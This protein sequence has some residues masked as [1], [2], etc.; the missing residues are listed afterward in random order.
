M[1][2]VGHVDVISRSRIAG[3]VVDL[4]VPDKSVSVSVHVNGRLRG[5]CWASLPRAGVMLPSGEAAPERCA[6]RLE[7]DPPL[8][9]FAEQRIEVMET[10]S[11]RAILNG[12]HILAPPKRHEFIDPLTPVLI[13][14]A[15]RS[16]TTWLMS[17]LACH[18]D[19]VLAD[20]YPY[21]I[22]Q[23]AYYVAAFRALVAS[24]DRERST[25]P[26][27]MFEA[28]KDRLIGANPYYEPD[29][30]LANPGTNLRDFY[31]RSI[32]EHYVMLFGTL[33]QKFYRILADSQQKRKARFFCEK[34]TLDETARQGARMFFNHVKE[35]VV[36]RDPGDLLCS[37]IAFWKHPPDRAM[38]LLRTAIHELHRIVREATSD[39]L[40]IRYEDLVRAPRRTSGV[41]SD[42]LGFD[43]LSPLA[44]RDDAIPASHR[45]SENPDA[46]IGRWRYDLTSDQRKVLAGEFAAFMYEFGYD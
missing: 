20:Q 13:T 10:R 27:T 44:D 28:G 45:T 1:S 42:F 14:S 9:P 2:L 34:G 39:M 3:W 8:S 38:A 29:F 26:V 24:A 40:V 23:I 37:M 7:F 32:P 33:I 25:D 11:A 35:I 5:A 43:L 4:A 16:G 21:E 18:P 15:G 36:V 30:F 6:F 12:Q 19:V 46:S 41:L 22:K 17:Q 31:E